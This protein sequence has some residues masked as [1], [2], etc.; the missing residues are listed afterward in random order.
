VFLPLEKPIQLKAGEQLAF[1]LKRPELG[2]W[3]WTT[4]H[5]GKRQRQSTFLS[6]PLSPERLRKASERYQPKINERGEAARWLLAE[7]A[8]EATVNE[9]AER[10]QAQFRGTFASQADARA[11]VKHLVE[12]YS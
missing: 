3:T 5:A 6:Q 10:L 9:L 8:G 7:M 1:A 11:L 2:E 4:E 12:R